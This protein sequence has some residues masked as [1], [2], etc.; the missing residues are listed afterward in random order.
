MLRSEASE[1]ITGPDTTASNTCFQRPVITLQVPHSGNDWGQPGTLLILL[2][3]PNVR[4]GVSPPSTS[5]LS[6]VAASGPT[7][8]HGAWASHCC[9]F[10][11]W[12]PWALGHMGFSSCGLRAPERRLS[13]C[14]TWALV[15]PPHV[16]SS[17][18]RDLTQV[19]ALAEAS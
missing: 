11:H 19:S 17:Q 16:G 5:W 9:G 10:S 4:K 8:Y 7:L 18:T 3:V 15:A 1:P 14:G 13:S 6:L 2:R 12:G